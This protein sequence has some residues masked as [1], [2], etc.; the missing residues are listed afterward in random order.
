MGL[1]SLTAAPQP[2]TKH[3]RWLRALRKGLAL[4]GSMGR[5]VGGRRVQRGLPAFQGGGRWA[6]L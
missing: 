3:L 6:S 2:G 1:G 5:V 4:H